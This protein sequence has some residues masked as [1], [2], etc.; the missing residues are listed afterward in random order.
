MYY[1]ISKADVP[2]EAD[3]FQ[4]T[5]W[6]HLWK[7]KA[8]LY[9][10][11]NLGDVLFLF[12]KNTQRFVWQAEV[13]DQPVLIKYSEKHQLLKDYT[14]SAEYFNDAPSSGYLFSYRLTPIKYLDASRPE[15]FKFRRDGWKDVD[16]DFLSSD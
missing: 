16:G 7:I 8:A 9:K 15:D 6:F 4:R 3:E 10:E 2:N 14:M 13:I 1:A 12:D 11:L 5:Q